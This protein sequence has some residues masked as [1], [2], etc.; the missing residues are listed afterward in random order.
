[1]E[2]HALHR[3]LGLQLV[4]EMPGDGLTLAVLISCEEELV[5]ALERTFQVGDRLLLL[6]GDHVIRK[7]AVFHIDG[8]LAERALL[9]LRRQIFRLDQVA[10][11]ADRGQHFVSVAQILGN[12]LRLCGRLDYDQ[13]L[14]A[15]HLTPRLLRLAPPLWVSG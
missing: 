15:R 14:R 6:V 12:R 2:H 4:E 1:M 7:K 10:D 8:E 11:V 9:K 5:G 3:N 13:L